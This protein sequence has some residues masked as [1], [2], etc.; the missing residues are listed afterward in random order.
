MHLRQTL[1][2]WNSQGLAKLTAVAQLAALRE[3]RS[4][5]DLRKITMLD[6]PGGRESGDRC[7]AGSALGSEVPFRFG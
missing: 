7:T 6:L 1:L 4:H 3:A 2:R 5:L